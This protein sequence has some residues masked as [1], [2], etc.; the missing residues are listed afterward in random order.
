MPFVETLEA[1]CG[2]YRW[3]SKYF[4]PNSMWITMLVT[5]ENLMSIPVY[6]L[7]RSGAVSTHSCFLFNLN[8]RLVSVDV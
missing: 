1:F 7:R 3:T 6:L 5:A 2:D 8:R 4:K